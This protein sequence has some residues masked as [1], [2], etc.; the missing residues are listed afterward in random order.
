MA[1]T[2]FESAGVIA[3]MTADQAVMLTRELCARLAAEGA[4]FHGNI[5]PGN[6]NID[7]EGHAHLGKGS[8]APASERSAD[9]VE[10]LAPEFFWDGDGT[11]ASDVYSLGLFL[12]A[13]C[14]GGFLPFQPKN[15]E[16]TEKNRSSALRRRMKG[17][18]FILPKG[19][20]EELSAVL[21]KALAYD[22]AE[23]YAD[24]A[25]LLA[26]L[27]ATDEA[28]PGGPVED[29]PADEPVEIPAPEETVVEAELPVEEEPAVEAP[30]PAEPPLKEPSEP[31]TRRYAVQKDVEEKKSRRQ[32]PSAPASRKKKKA[33]PLVPILTI[34]AAAV[35][36]AVLWYVLNHSFGT[37]APTVSET[38]SS[39][40][41]V[42]PAESPEATEPP[43]A[44]EVHVATINE[45]IGGEDEES[46]ED[47]APADDTGTADENVTGSASIDG[48]DVTAA[49]GTVYVTGTGVNLRSG[50]GTS[51]DVA[52]TLSRGT[53]LT[54]TG[55]VNGWTQVWY[56][57]KEYYV[58]S[59]LV[60]TEDPTGGE[61]ETAEATPAPTA[62]PAPGAGSSTSSAYSVAEGSG[63]LVVTSDVNVR[64]GPGTSYSVLGIARV[65]ETLTTT[66]TADEGKWY[67]VT[68]N[69]Q[70]GYVN[71]KLV[72]VQGYSEGTSTTTATSGGT[73][74]VIGDVNIRSGPGT[75]Y[76]IIG[77]AKAG[78]TLE[79][80]NHTATNW[81]EVKQGDKTGFVAGN[82]VREK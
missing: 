28:L 3:G 34:V 43:Q 12:Y 48:V 66:G 29:I 57:G 53:K 70:T 47:E 67:R 51:Y 1:D 20:T 60:S 74:E 42:L 15:G 38:V 21:E 32:A 72:S 54:R 80:I 24:P 77:T 4:G 69:G 78:A 22:P 9:Q 50:P 81:Y 17:E 2:G 45:L 39:P 33:S 52:T 26:A 8:D 62:T 65:G 13:G 76:D 75:G 25:A 68:Y 59:S 6:V 41:I 44:E 7:E 46:A 5:W 30:T 61:T 82:Y 18:K 31:E 36:I 64:S 14:S 16:L 23:R 35:V 71:R 63:Q 79:Y 37:S 58:S 10:F 73:L 49:E 27:G 55:T 19:L 11:P 40:V 56:N